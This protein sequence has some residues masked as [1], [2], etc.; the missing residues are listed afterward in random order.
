[1]VVRWEPESTFRLRIPG[2]QNLALVLCPQSALAPGV[3]DALGSEV[4]PPA[5]N[6]GGAGASGGKFRDYLCALVL[7]GMMA[8]AYEVNMWRQAVVPVERME[9]EVILEYDPVTRYYYMSV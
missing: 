4:S 1:M 3:R 8:G 9:A 5:G 6:A 7:P 2:Q